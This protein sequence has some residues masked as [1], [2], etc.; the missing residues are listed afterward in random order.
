MAITLGDHLA[1]AKGV[2]EPQRQSN[3][4]I[5]LH[6]GDGASASYIMLSLE[7][8]SLP[9]ESNEEVSLEY[10]NIR[11]YV[12]GKTMYDTIPLVVKDMVD[13]NVAAAVVAWRQAVYNPIT[14]QIGLAKNYKKRATIVLFAPDGSHERTWDL[15]GVWPMS[16]NYG[17]LDMT[18]SDK[19]TIETVLRY[20][21]AIPDVG[22]S[23]LSVSSI[24]ANLGI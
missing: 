18:S 20:D 23:A 7:A 12:A 22:A 19:V 4:L 2:F 8:S 21:K 24:L 11:R 17:V 1:Q 14:D 9:T 15:I 10:L 3:F 16:V 13:V 6:L 5:H